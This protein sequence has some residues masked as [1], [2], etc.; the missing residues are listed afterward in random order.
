MT[1]EIIVSGFGGQGVILLGQLLIQAGL[2]DGKNVSSIP[3]YGPEMRG[4]TAYCSVIIS[5]RMVGSPVVDKPTLLVALNL[6]SML[7]FEPAIRPGGTMLLNTSLV[8]EAPKRDDI[9]VCNIALNDMAAELNN[10]R[11]LNVIGLGAVAGMGTVISKEAA[12]KALDKMFGEKFASKPE[13]LAL[14]RASFEAGYQA[15]RA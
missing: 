11:G 13:L 10:P 15:I 7:R 1:H 8:A 14:N 4:G 5:E 6:P 12:Y 2:I 9:R 3:A